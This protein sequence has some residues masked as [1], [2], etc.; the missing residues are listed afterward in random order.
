MPKRIVVLMEGSGNAFDTAPSNVT[1]TLGLIA[2]GP[3]P[4]GEVEQWAIGTMVSGHDCVAF[5][6]K[7]SNVRRHSTRSM[8]AT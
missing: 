5:T 3:V 1:R 6:K 7:K 2:L 8:H 4:T